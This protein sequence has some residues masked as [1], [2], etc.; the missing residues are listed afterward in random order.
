[1]K[2]PNLL[3]SK[4][5]KP[6]ISAQGD[7][8]V[9]KQVL[10]GVVMVAASLM[11]AFVA[12]VPAASAQWTV[13]DEAGLAPKDGTADGS[14]DGSGLIDA[15]ENPDFTS[16]VESSRVV[17]RSWRTVGEETTGFIPAPFELPP[18]DV[19]FGPM[20]R[21][22]ASTY[23]TRY[24]LRELNK[25]TE[26]RNQGSCGAC[27][28]FGAM[29][30]VESTLMGG[31]QWDFSENNMKNEHGFDYGHCYGGNYTMAAAYLA[32][33][34]GPVDEADDPYNA[35]SDVSP[36]NVDAQKVVK[37]IAFLPGRTG[38]LNN[39]DI[40]AA[41]MEHGAV[42]V[43]FY[44]GSGY[45]NSATRAYYH[46]GSYSSNHAVA[47]VGWDD[48]YPASNFKTTPPG[49][50]AFIVRNSWGS[51]WGDGGYFYVSYYD[52]R[53]AYSTNMVVDV[54]A[55]AVPERHVYQHDE[56]G[57][58]TSTGFGRTSAWMA[59]VFTAGGTQQIIESVGFY[60]VKENAEYEV[61]IHLDPDQGPLSSS[62]AVYT[63][64]GTLQ[65][66]GLRSVTLDEPVTLEPGQVFSV[67]VKLTIPNYYYPIPVERPYSNYASQAVHNPGESFTS[68]DG[69]SWT[70]YSQ[71]T[72]NVCVKAY[73][74]DVPVVADSDDDGLLDAWETQYFGDLSRNGLGDF[75]QDGLTDMAEHDA[76]T[77]P[78]LQ[79]TDGDTMP[80]GWEVSNGLEP[81]LADANQDFD[82][83]TYTNLEEL[84]AN[85]DPR[86]PASSPYDID[87]DGLPDSWEMQWFGSTWQGKY[88]DYDQ[89][90]IY[91]LLEYT[92]GSNPTSQDT[93][94]DM[95]PDA[96]ERQQGF[97]LLTPDGDLDA[98]ADGFSNAEEYESATDP[99]NERDFPG[100]TDV[101]G[102][103]MPDAWEIQ[104]FGNISQGKYWDS[105]GDGIYNLKEYELG[106]D[107][108][109]VDTDGDG[110]SDSYEVK[111]GLD[112]NSSDS[113]APGTGVLDVDSDGMDDAWE[114]QYFE[115]IG[116]GKY[117]DFDG[118]GIYNLKEYE[119]G[120]DPTSA[121]TDADGLPDSWELEMGFDPTVAGSGI[122]AD[123]DG[124]S[125]LDEFND[126]T[127]PNNE[128]DF[129]GAVDVDGDG[130]PDAWEVEF[131]GSVSQGK[132]WDSDGDGTYNLAEYN[133][134]TDPSDP[135]SF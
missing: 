14:G 102:D 126:G 106:T 49:D 2:M 31:E 72:G 66:R 11:L 62:G 135:L 93:D 16:F 33:G 28:A 129:L 82:G 22:S 38:A 36:D 32:R 90:G 114:I 112:P 134:G 94:G 116:Q 7:G 6:R 122:D 29:A 61:Q 43:A 57:W 86:D 23:P 127:D 123:G 128:R 133:N 17:L 55:P 92:L 110:L 26:V 98:D 68:S 51:G 132:Y 4:D 10:N 71:Y 65:K 120:T 24:D 97:D 124:F 39:D 54:M 35:S 67:V 45:Y 130:M 48:D 83:D 63:T 73:T 64:T 70:D 27:W 108:T 58:V 37:G 101:D 88:W 118:D 42:G 79:D 25:L 91:N 69:N 99:L 18:A 46:S 1:M 34:Q 8:R 59:N 9:A 117:W 96:W 104:Y 125:N 20:L 50:G 13:A 52:S 87:Q 5:G 95:M 19:T 3:R 105:D 78:T 119:L 100:A 84:I 121:D 74:K 77:D 30:T 60:A 40:K 80:D 111:A 89:D 53:M 115:G 47:I 81:L 131:F 76:G 113:S 103:F 12:L 109:L 85:T 56:L 15:P 44:W 21:S 75:D 107:P 41:V